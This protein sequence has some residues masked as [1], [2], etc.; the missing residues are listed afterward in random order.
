MTDCFVHTFPGEEIQMVYNPPEEID[1]LQLV[2]KAI[3]FIEEFYTFIQPLSA[4][5]IV[6]FRDVY[7]STVSNIEPS[8]PH[9]YIQASSAPSHII[10]KAELTNPNPQV[11]QVIHLSPDIMFN[12]LKAALEQDIPSPDY[13]ITWCM[14]HINSTRTRLFNEHKF[15]HKQSF[16]LDADAG[17]LNIPI[18]ILEDGLWVS[19]PVEEISDQPPI[20]LYINQDNG[21]LSTRLMIHWSLWTTPEKPE[22]KALQSSISRL[23]A[24]GWE[25]S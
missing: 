13:K 24:K 10:L 20:T 12:W 6:A 2:N 18:E 15:R 7:W 4:D 25:Q 8:F 9:W 1:D 22:Q 21:G 23:I 19:G 14:I 11:S 3:E 16:L 5:L 17:K